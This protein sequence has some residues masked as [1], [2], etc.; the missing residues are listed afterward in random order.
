MVT[1][2]LV[3]LSGGAALAA[4]SAVDEFAYPAGDLNNDNGGSGFSDAWTQTA[5]SGGPLSGS[6]VVASPSL[7]YPELQSGGGAVTLTTPVSGTVSN[8]HTTTTYS[9]DLSSSPQASGS[10]AYFSFLI[11]PNSIGT[12]SGAA[13]LLGNG[14]ISGAP[15]SVGFVTGT[16]GG[17]YWGLSDENNNQQASTVQPADGATTLFV[18][19]ADF[20]GGTNGSSDVFKL[21]VN[22]TLGAGQPGNP[23][24][25][26][27]ASAFDT[28]P[29]LTNIELTTF[30]AETEN[31]SY[32]FD[33]LRVGSSYSSV[34][35]VPEPF[36]LL[37]LIALTPLTFLR[38]SRLGRAALPRSSD[39]TRRPL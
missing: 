32:T 12:L 28:L 37:S 27:T 16:H 33:E 3:L 11:R 30:G 25:T 4:P 29:P 36:S 7:T 1:F 19:E 35:P 13:V 21:Y 5:I 2:A 6:G 23:D 9:R 15:L 39:P 8:D 18:V 20:A 38:P 24:A 22:P 10:V 34:T 14:S 31:D 26:L 17:A